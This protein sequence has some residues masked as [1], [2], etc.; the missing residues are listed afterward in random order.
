MSRINLNSK[1]LYQIMLG[2]DQNILSDLRITRK[3]GDVLIDAV[4]PAHVRTK[5]GSIPRR[6]DALL[7]YPSAENA[8]K[9]KFMDVD[10]QYI[11]ADV[12]PLE[13]IGREAA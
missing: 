4:I 7:S 6:I 1:A 5:S 9:L 10:V 2:W 3:V 13:Y 12:S 11:Y 8:M